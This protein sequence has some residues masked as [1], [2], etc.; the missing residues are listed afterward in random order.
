MRS[1]IVTALEEEEELYCTY[2]SGKEAEKEG[3]KALLI[4]FLLLE[5]SASLESEQ[6][7]RVG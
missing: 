4:S 2:I 5:G 7:Q 1:K 6:R 3:R